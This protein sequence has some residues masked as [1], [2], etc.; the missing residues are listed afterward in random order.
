MPAPVPTLTDVLVEPHPASP[1]SPG[2]A[3]VPVQRLSRTPPEPMRAAARQAALARWAIGAL[4]FGALAV[5]A[6]AIGRLAIHRLLLRHGRIAH[7][8]I[9]ELDVRRLRVSD[10]DAPRRR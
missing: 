7:L 1:P 5:G 10:V 4:A 2:K 8:Q 3:R 9:D 6:L